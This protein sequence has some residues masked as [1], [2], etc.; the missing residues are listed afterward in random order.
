MESPPLELDEDKL[1]AA[2]ADIL[3]Q[4]D[5]EKKPSEPIRRPEFPDLMPQEDVARLEA[6]QDGLSAALRQKWAEFS[7]AA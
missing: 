6:K 5:G 4:E 1:D 2:I 3:K 7:G